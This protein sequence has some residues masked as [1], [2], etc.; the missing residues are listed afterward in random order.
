MSLSIKDLT[1]G[2]VKE[3]FED[4]LKGKRCTAHIGYPVEKYMIELRHFAN[5]FYYTSSIIIVN[6]MCKRKRR[7]KLLP[8]RFEIKKDLFQKFITGGFHLKPIEEKDRYSDII[9]NHILV[10]Q[11]IPDHFLE[12]L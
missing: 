11:D 5:S 8:V 9:Y 4:E 12:T 2:T 7:K 6:F 3:L 10:E 1:S